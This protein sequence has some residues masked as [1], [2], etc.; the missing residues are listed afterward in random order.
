M[1]RHVRHLA[2][3]LI[4]VTLL[5]IRSVLLIGAYICHRYDP[6][7]AVGTGRRKR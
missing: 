5:T 4:A 2:G 7:G 1:R 6:S 3:S